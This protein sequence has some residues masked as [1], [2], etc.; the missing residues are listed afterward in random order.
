MHLGDPEPAADLDQLAPGHRHAAAPASAASTSSTAAA[1]LLTTSA[2]SAPQARA[3]SAPAWSLARAPPPGRRGRARGW[4]SRPG[5]RPRSGARPRLVCSSTPVALTTGRS[6]P[7]APPRPGPRA[8]R[9]AARRWPAGRVDQQR[10]GQ[11]AS[12]PADRASASTDGG[13]ARGPRGHRRT[14]RAGPGPT[15]PTGTKPAAANPSTAA[16]ST[17]AS[18]PPDVWGSK[19]ERLAGRRRRADEVAVEVGA[20]ARVAARAHARGRR[21]RRTP[22]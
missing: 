4:C 6:R 20:V 3:S 8:A 15:V 13:R 17:A 5:R 18:R 16:G 12:A 14:T 10:V 2:A 9:V 22:G 7:A 19:R 21:R 1:P 11:P